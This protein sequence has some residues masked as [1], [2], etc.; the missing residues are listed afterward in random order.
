MFQVLLHR[1]GNANEQ[2]LM[3][4]IMDIKRAQEEFERTLKQTESEVRDTRETIPSLLEENSD[5]KK[6]ICFI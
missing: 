5:L 6:N 1:L 4:E 2:I 3:K